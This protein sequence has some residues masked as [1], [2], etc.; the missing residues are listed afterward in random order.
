MLANALT[1]SGGSAKHLVVV[2]TRQGRTTARGGRLRMMARD[3]LIKKGLVYAPERGELAFTVPDMHE[4][5]A[6]QD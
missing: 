5:I 1:H 4:F 6:R 2:G 3:E